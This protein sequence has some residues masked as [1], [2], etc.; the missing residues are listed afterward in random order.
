MALL[1]SPFADTLLKV[2]RCPVCGAD[3]G[4]LLD[5]QFLITSSFACGAKFGV[6]ACTEIY[7]HS[8]CPAGSEVAV[9]QLNAETSARFATKA[10][11]A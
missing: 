6:H 9:R 1:S 4:E 11:A 8:A 3:R 2:K 10:G 7:V 5:E